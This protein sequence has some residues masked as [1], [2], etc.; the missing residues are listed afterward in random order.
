MSIRPVIA[1]VLGL[2]MGSAHAADITASRQTAAS[3]K[4]RAGEAEFRAL[5]KELVEIN[6]TL[7]VGSCTEAAN[8]MKARLSAAGFADEQLHVIVPP[9]RPK[10]GNLVAVLPGSDAKLKPLLLLAHIDVVEA[11]RADWERDPFKLVEEGG[12]FYARGASDDKAMAAVFAD[13]MVRFKKDGYRPKRTIKLALTCGEETPNTFNGVSYLIEHHRELIDAG[14]ALNEG[15]GGRYDQKTGVYR[16]VAVLT[17]EKVY[18]DFTLTTHNQGGH[19]S[20][21]TP[22]NAI[23]QLAHALDKVEAHQFKVEFN[24]TSR[25]YFEKF[26]AIEGGEK[27]ADMIAAAKNWRRGGHRTA[28]EG[29][30]DQRHPAHQLRGHAA[31]GRA[32]AQRPAPARDGERQLPHVPRPQRRGSPAGTHRGHWRSGSERRISGAAGKTR[33]A[34][35][36]VARSDGADR[37]AEPRHVS[38]RRRDPDHQL[39]RHRRTLPHA[40]GHSD[41][42]RIRHVERRRDQ[43]RAR[44][45]RAHPRAD[46]D[47]RPRVSLSAHEGIRGRQVADQICR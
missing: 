45:Q 34:A 20:R 17:S 5:Y 40:G 10:D 15:G 2:T 41:L 29:S 9:G 19:S 46:A 24:D 12:F 8:A 11:N 22:D 31:R 42:W 33:R 26:G 6:T 14:F 47:R 16:Y 1:I 4:A 13:S 25:A 36:A 32:R 27:G 44:A 28:Q 35:A 30:V 37:S 7:S 38:R 39:R 21:P 43:Q 23:Y 18:Q 3:A